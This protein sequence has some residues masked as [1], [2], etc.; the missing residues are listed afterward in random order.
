MKLQ[1]VVCCLSAFLMDLGSLPAQEKTWIGSVDASWTNGGNWS[2]SPL[3]PELES[4][5]YD[6]SS[7]FNLTQ[8]LDQHWSITG[9]RVTSASS[10]ITILPGAGNFVLTNS[11]GID[12]S[13]AT[14]DVTLLADYYPLND[15]TWSV[16]AGRTLTVSNVL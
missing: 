2:P 9:L 10:P 5:L 12:L 1:H 6:S 15:G 3:A 16:A 7:A 13:A 14:A 8:T 11:G 4:V